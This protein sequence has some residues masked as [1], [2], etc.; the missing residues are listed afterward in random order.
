MI[1][2][3]S[4]LD[5]TELEIDEKILDEYWAVRDK[6]EAVFGKLSFSA[7]IA[8]GALTDKIKKMQNELDDYHR[9]Q[10][11][12]RRKS[13]VAPKAAVVQA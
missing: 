10:R 5:V 7:S 12:E 4:L 2:N 9:Q 6:Y 13:V 3:E 1:G 11:E 8:P